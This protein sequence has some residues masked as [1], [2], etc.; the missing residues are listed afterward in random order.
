MLTKLVERQT[1]DS[2]DCHLGE[3]M[4]GLLKVITCTCTCNSVLLLDLRLISGPPSLTSL[5]EGLPVFN[6]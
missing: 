1:A 3:L 5:Y 6:P 2:I 4:P